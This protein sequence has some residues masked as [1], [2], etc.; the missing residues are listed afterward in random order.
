MKKINNFN[1]ICK[2]IGIP[3]ALIRKIENSLDEYEGKLFLIGGCVRGLILKRKFLENPDLVV[4]LDFSILIKCLNKSRIRFLDIGSKFGSA[5]I[6]VGN[7]KF[8]ITSTRNDLNPD[9]RWTKIKFTKNLLEDSKRRD[10]TFNSI[11]CDLNGN[12]YDPNGG[13]ED[14]ANKK[15]R[16]I[17]DADLRINEDYLRILRFIRFS[18]DIRGCLEKKALRI[19]NQNSKKL[20]KLS[21]ERR[22]Q[23][24]EKIIMNYNIEKKEIIEDLRTI[25]QNTLESKVNIN[26]FI[27]LCKLEDKY[28][29]RSFERRLK[30]LFRSK[31]A[32][33]Y[34][35]LESSDKRLK[36]RLEKNSLIKGY[37]E[38]KLNFL[39]Y[40]IEKNNVIDQLFIDF[41]DNI[42]TKQDF[43][44][45]YDKILCFKKKT[46][47]LNGKD[48]FKIGFKPGKA[49]GKVLQETE[50]WWVKNNFT[51]SKSE[52]LK[53]S[54][55]F[56]P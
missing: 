34:L 11:Y 19:C 31:K 51:K 5:V 23:E 35:I 32:I 30:F 17:G 33:P 40:K 43:K 25:I 16:F 42:I 48:L 13:I 37:S 53:F 15:V 45:F 39:L 55:S 50:L 7:K 38:N 2:Q 1:R 49:M 3:I 9:G 8:D 18:L 14:L 44:K 46:F 36:K 27:K 56:L 4:N 21:Y 28:N 41:S 10:F 22:M 26:N 20:K 12:I 47:P 52:C 24:L 54:K 6:V 29:N